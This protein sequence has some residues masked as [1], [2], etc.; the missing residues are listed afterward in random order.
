M[1][2]ISKILATT[3]SLT[4]LAPAGAA[5]AWQDSSSGDSS[6]APSTASI[7]GTNP[8]WIIASGINS[9]TGGKTAVSPWSRF[10][11]HNAAHYGR[12]LISTVDSL[13][14]GE[15]DGKTFSE[16]CKQADAIIWFSGTSTSSPKKRVLIP[17]YKTMSGQSKKT[18]DVNKAAGNWD[19]P[20][21]LTPEKGARKLS[22][23][24]NKFIKDDTN[25]SDYAAMVCYVAEP[26]PDII[27][28]TTT[29]YDTKVTTKT[30][31]DVKTITSTDAYEADH[32]YAVA[33]DDQFMASSN[34][35]EPQELVESKS[36]FG[37][38]FDQLDE[39]EDG[40]DSLTKKER[41]S[42]VKDIEIAMS[43]DKKSNQ[44]HKVVLTDNNKKVFADGGVVN[45]SQ[46]TLKA[47]IIIDTTTVEGATT[48]VKTTQ[49][50][51]RVGTKT[52]TWNKALGKYNPVPKNWKWGKWENVGD[53]VVGDPKTVKK[54]DSF[55][56]V[57]KEYG[58]LEST[59]FWQMI[60][61]NCNE[62]GF[63][64]L[65][66]A[67]DGASVLDLGDQNSNL[68]SV[69]RTKVYDSQPAILDFG[70]S[71]A[72]GIA[73]TTSG[74]DFYDKE[75]PFDC[76]PSNSSTNGASS[77]NTGNGALDNNTISN[78]SVSTAVKTGALSDGVNSNTFT[79]F[80]D[81]E[82]KSIRVNTW[83]P[84]NLN[85]VRY[86][87]QA[88]LTTTVTRWAEGTPT[89]DGSSGG[90]FSMKSTMPGGEA[91]ELFQGN[92][93][94]ENQRNW[95]T[96]TFSNSTA[97]IL[98]GLHNKFSV[99][100]TWASEKDRPQILNFKWEYAPEIKTRF[101]VELG[102]SSNNADGISSS[103]FNR[104]ATMS[105]NTDTYTEAEGKCY[106][107]FGTNTSV[108]TKDAFN[109]NTGTGTNN[110]LDGNLFQGTGTDNN[111]NLF[112]NFVRATTE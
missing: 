70:D 50:K 49:K 79:F 66:S 74:I 19:K 76:T 18:K 32:T 2:K 63:N 24:E 13:R 81:N 21:I 56:E 84:K 95:N 101:P 9:S 107:N 6:N 23:S 97:T 51:K 73:K 35:W 86:S 68:T 78:V 44:A 16:F 40:D 45:V 64:S 104:S 12:T 59:G 52:Q 33:I 87:G 42:L 93:N 46:Y 109:T 20:A 67:T 91:I 96:K 60:L 37:K 38:L 112:I 77:E 62:L 43:V 100:G 22:K 41:A 108:S 30:T 11:D 31:G 92:D 5:F 55:S 36:N 103:T 99:Q 39:T 105:S 48:T 69:G 72:S 75:C 10:V 28:Q 65:L 57:T 1:K 61:V 83:Y 4:L 110:D 3:L 89:L 90:K 94:K 106:A 47:K 98:D 88:P 53:P 58:D 111:T 26:R 71:N 54:N 82:P 34:E 7:S 14:P 8:K 27:T 25:P 80:R 102:I 85:F 17:N 29:Q 15:E